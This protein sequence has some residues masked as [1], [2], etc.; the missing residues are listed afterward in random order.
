MEASQAPSGSRYS[1]VVVIGASANGIESLQ[2]I[3]SSLQGT[4]PAPIVIAQH[5][6]PDRAS[7]RG[8]ALDWIGTLPIQIVGELTPLEPGVVY[9][10]PLGHSVEIQ[11]DILVP[12]E[13][14]NYPQ[15]S[16]DL[17]FTSAAASMEENV[18]AI[19][20]AGTG[21]DG[22][23]G[24][25]EVKY[26][27]GTV[28]IENP[29]ATAPSGIPVSLS[30]SVVDIVANRDRIGELLNE[31]LAGAFVIP[32]VS[33]HAQLQQLLEDLREESGIDFT[34]YK[35][36]TIERRLQ[37][38]MAATEQDTITDYIRHLHAHPEEYQRLVNGFL[39]KVT[40]FFRD[41]DLFAYLGE[42]VL[43]ELIRE[44]KEKGSD[45]R[46]WSAG[47][48]T[49][50][51]AYSL[52]MLVADVLGDDWQNINVRIFA[53]DLDEEAVAFARRGIYPGRS[54]AALSSSMVHRHFIERGGDY[55]VRKSLRTMLVFGEHNLGQ[56]APFPRID[57][58]LC[59][60]VLIYFTP[61]LQRRS[62]QL[63]AFSLRSGGYLVLGKSETV[64][65][66]AEFFAVD[67]PRMKVFRRIGNR[68]LIP[69]SRIRDAMP[70]AL[71]ILAARS[72][73]FPGASRVARPGRSRATWQSENLL[74]DLPVGVIVVDRHYDLQFI[75]GVARRLL[76]IHAAAVEQDL[77]LL[78]QHFDAV[79]VRRA[80]D[81]VFSGEANVNVLLSTVGEPTDA[82]QTIELTGRPIAQ[83]D[84]EA[85]E[86]VALT[87]VDVTEQERLRQRHANV[88]NVTSRLI[89]TN[90]ELLNA[91]QDL[92]ATI[93]RL[94]A[95]NEE[96]MVAAEEIQAATEE[97]ETL[98]EELQA[99]NEE[100]ETLNEE[101]QATVE[102][103]NT[104]NDDLQARTV[105]L[106]TL[107]IEGEISRQQLRAIL[108]ALEIATIVMDRHGSIVI[109][110]ETY[111]RV[112]QRQS[113]QSRG[114]VDEEGTPLPIGSTPVHRAM[115]GEA[116]IQRFGISSG[117][118]TTWYVANS[119]NID[120]TDS[121]RLTLLSLREA[122]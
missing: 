18:I 26:A 50:E 63:F 35:Y 31:L 55:E 103:L 64:S 100:L 19:V 10:V 4:F 13:G 60:N 22:A 102:E 39:I 98:N 28:I 53:T 114:M 73:P 34:S 25:R 40:E 48:A 12:V 74:L 70:T 3:F 77:V 14:E 65:P 90:A 5:L 99:S 115:N 57:L 94:R 7:T 2:A 37:R 109:E 95:E 105:E 29:E 120:L 88:E 21:S 41:P 36:A 96:M 45:L 86:L 104:T 17:L 97:V 49:G 56:R 79:A 81:A 15:S 67:Q 82:Q 80:I 44:A 52:A 9:V 27:G 89:L 76:G 112:F 8:E 87:I 68:A 84:G 47:C 83:G 116:F 61:A 93:S 108:D 117:E 58:I 54:L 32:P 30:P 106:Q 72:K 33:E 11:A 42:H 62:L 110:S 20:L 38:R 66:L 121:D 69:P 119:V 59:R 122:E 75:N 107:A 71:P 24:A 111:R 23:I 1:H 118:G 85:D 16:I 51:E 6:D 43:P 101:L 91:N 78:V 46:I 113:D 92:S